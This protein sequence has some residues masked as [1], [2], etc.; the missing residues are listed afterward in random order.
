MTKLETPKGVNCP[1]DVYHKSSRGSSSEGKCHQQRAVR[2][3]IH[4]CQ[5]SN[6]MHDFLLLYTKPGTSIIVLIPLSFCVF[7]SVLRK[8][9]MKG[10][11]GVTLNSV[12]AFLRNAT[13]RDRDY[14]AFLSE[15][16]DDALQD[17]LESR[18]LWM[19]CSQ[20]R[21]VPAGWEKKAHRFTYIGFGTR[22]TFVGFGTRLKKRA[23]TYRKLNWFLRAHL[24]ERSLW[25]WSCW[26]LMEVNQMATQ[27][28]SI[29]WQLMRCGQAKEFQISC[30][31]LLEVF[32]SFFVLLASSKCSWTSDC[33]NW[34]HESECEVMILRKLFWSA[35][36]RP[37][38]LD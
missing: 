37:R 24:Y 22:F 7:H 13:R 10:L 25:V 16:Q 30:I 4:D 32:V 8:E 38:R 1:V 3:G 19:K 27:N 35:L 6:A 33:T 36:L 9:L 17:T 26:Q 11:V 2:R 18:K 29:R 12:R 23:R 34:A 14:Q 31:A 21:T 15:K 28:N 5:T 20:R